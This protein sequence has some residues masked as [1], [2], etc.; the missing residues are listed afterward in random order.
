MY[1]VV[2]IGLHTEM[3]IYPQYVGKWT[4]KWPRSGLELEE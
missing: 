3:S 2:Q 4:R 1:T